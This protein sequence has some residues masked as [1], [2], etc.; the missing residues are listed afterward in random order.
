MHIHCFLLCVLNIQDPIQYL[1]IYHIL[2][3]KI[4]E[5]YL[6]SFLSTYNASYGNSTDE[7]TE[8][9]SFLY[10]FF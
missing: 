6:L 8:K 9:K 10:P 4:A 1:T 3:L 2:V 5:I 7:M